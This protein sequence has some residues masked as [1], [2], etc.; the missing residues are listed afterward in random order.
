M[1]GHRRGVCWIVNNYDFSLSSGEHKNREGTQLDEKRLRCVFTWLGFQVEVIS[2]TTGQQM[3]SSLRELAQRD[4][5]RG[6]C[7]ACVVLSHGDTGCVYGVDG[8]AVLLTELMELLGG[9]HCVTLRGKPKLLFIQ[10]CQG[11][12]TQRAVCVQAD[13]PD[14]DTSPSA[15]AP[16]SI[17]SDAAPSVVEYVPWGADILIGM[18]TVPAYAS[19]RDLQDG[20]WYI[21][22]LC[23][24]LVQMVPRGK[25]LCSILMQVNADVSEMVDP[26]S[27]MRQIPMPAFSLRKPV[28]FPVPAEPSPIL[29]TSL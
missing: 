22:S 25:D 18:A 17:C 14:T 28:V 7:M 24:N 12:P 20:T 13:G 2:D 4:H 8:K 3:L 19:L 6:D 10:A 16:G 15:P 29:P 21:K 11:K 26:R 5:S 9:N 23:Q 27:S 1:T